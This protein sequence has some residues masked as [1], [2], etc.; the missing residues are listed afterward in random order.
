LL[1]KKIAELGAQLGGERLVVAEHERGLLHQLDDP[2][3]RHR[4]A[5]ARDA[6]QRLRPVAAE[7]ALGQRLRGDRL[8]LTRSNRSGMV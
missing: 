4:L 6:Q 2:G 3:H 1:G 7:H 8:G 5:A